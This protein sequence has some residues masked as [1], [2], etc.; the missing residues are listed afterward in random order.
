MTERSLC[1]AELSPPPEPYDPEANPSLKGI[2]DEFRVVNAAIDEA[3]NTLLNEAAKKV[4][5]GILMDCCKKFFNF[6]SRKHVKMFSSLRLALCK[7][8]CIMYIFILCTIFLYV[9]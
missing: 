7:N 9:A 8:N 2:L 3:I 6:M 5:E 4:S 1:A